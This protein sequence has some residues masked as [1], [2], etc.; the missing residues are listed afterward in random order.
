MVRNKKKMQPALKSADSRL[1]IS[2]TCEGELTNWEK[3]LA[4]SIKNGAPGGVTNLQLISTRNEFRTVPEAGSRLY[5]EAIHH[6]SDGK[7]EPR[8]EGVDFRELCLLHDALLKI[9]G[10][11]SN[12]Y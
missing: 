3:R 5:G 2:A 6:S 9:F 12:N 8:H 10:K 7:R 4:T 11:A 1:T